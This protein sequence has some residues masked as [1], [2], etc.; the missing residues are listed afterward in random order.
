MRGVPRPRLAGPALP[1]F[2]TSRPLAPERGGRT[3]YD[4]GYDVRATGML[5][6]VY[7]KQILSLRRNWNVYPFWFDWRKDLNVSA[8]ELRTH[9][10]TKIGEDAPVHIIGH[11][12]G[13]LVT[14]T[15]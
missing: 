10:D 15:F 4:P 13:G 3:R 8:D 14:R 2:E 11:S 1:R 12:M 5:L 6:F 9:I 7:W